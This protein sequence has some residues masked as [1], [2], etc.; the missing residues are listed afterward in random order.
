M[1]TLL[2]SYRN[3][4]L[5]DFM[6]LIE[7]NSMYVGVCWKEHLLILGN[8]FH[9]FDDLEDLECILRQTLACLE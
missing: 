8:S 1:D 5:Y 3:Q 4:V 7:A 6:D 2:L 9:Y